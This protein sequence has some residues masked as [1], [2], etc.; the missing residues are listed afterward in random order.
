MSYPLQPGVGLAL[1]LLLLQYQRSEMKQAGRS[2][3]NTRATGYTD[4]NG[5]NVYPWY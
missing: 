5:H 4:R 2:R 3:E 1:E